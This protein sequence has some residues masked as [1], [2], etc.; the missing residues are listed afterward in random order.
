MPNSLLLLAALLAATTA[1]RAEPQR[2]TEMV[3]GGGVTIET[4]VEGDGPA[5]VMLPSTGRDGAEDFDEVAA[6][7][8]RAGFRVLRPQPRG[9]F[10]STGPMQGVSLHD[11]AA[12]V[13][14]VIERL[15]GGRAVIVGH[16]F[17]HFVARMTAV[18]HP[19]AVRGVVLAAAA[20]SSW[21]ADIAKTPG[22]SGDLSLP[23]EERLAALRLGFFAPGHDPRPW[24]HGWFP[25]TQQMQA[26]SRE[27]AG[28]KQ[29]DWWGAG[30]APLLELIPADDP[31]KPR[32][33]WGELK[34]SYGE[35]VTTVVI[36]EASHA[37]FPEQ[38]GAV[39]EAVL[40]WVRGLPP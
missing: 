8:A 14:M 10:G 37:L 3:R 6:R 2:R 26:N 23:D 35:R 22:V 25:A 34:G 17:G 18:D 32:D 4:F 5:I 40:A 9:V 39:A 13:A 20:A 36:P 11:L 24:L 12:D 21:G 29:S 30:V 15:G 19:G 1:A 38:P 27:K 7:L 33:K 31:F 16:A 28:V